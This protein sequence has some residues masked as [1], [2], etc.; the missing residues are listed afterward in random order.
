MGVL[1][2]LDG[3]GDPGSMRSNPHRQHEANTSAMP[4]CVSLRLED[5]ILFNAHA[6]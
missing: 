4:L 3:S 1:C 6:M 2:R 5:L